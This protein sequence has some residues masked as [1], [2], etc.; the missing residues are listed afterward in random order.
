VRTQ[1]GAPSGARLTVPRAPEPTVGGAGLSVDPSTALDEGTLVSVHGHRLG[2]P[3]GTVMTLWECISG[4]GRADTDC[5]RSN[6]TAGLGPDPAVAFTSIFAVT[7]T[8]TTPNGRRVDCRASSG[9]CVIGVAALTPGPGLVVGRL[10]VATALDFAPR[11][12]PAARYVDQVFDHVTVHRDLAYVAR[13]GVPGGV[14]RLD[15]YEPTSDRLPSRPLIVWIHGGGY[16]IGAKE[17]MATWAIDW[18]RRGYVTASID[19]RLR[20][21]IEPTDP[22]ILDAAQDAAADARDA[23]VW[24]RNHERRYRID[25]NAIVVAGTSAGA[26]TALEVSYHPTSGAVL[27]AAAISLAGAIPSTAPVGDTSIPV[28]MFNGTDD[29]INPY[30]RAQHDCRRIRAAGATCRLIGY[31]GQG[32]GLD[33]LRPN[34]DVVAAD[35]LL[36]HVIRPGTPP[37]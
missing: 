7:A 18:A 26:A 19:Y 16:A 24:L 20:P 1:A 10:R 2:S 30:A 33:Q 12:H 23:L 6:W 35:F 14:L 29:S 36:Q 32:H 5:D 9:A 31:A 25:S 4:A 37:R 8:V 15:L 13:S 34:I 21:G 3:P 28:L 11:S 22:A 27:P 17:D